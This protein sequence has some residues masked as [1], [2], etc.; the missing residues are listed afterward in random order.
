MRAVWREVW[1][2]ITGRVT[3]TVACAVVRPWGNAGD[4]ERQFLCIVIRS[5]NRKGTVAGSFF[6]RKKKHI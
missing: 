1:G 4:A 3:S 5:D 6:L 2:N